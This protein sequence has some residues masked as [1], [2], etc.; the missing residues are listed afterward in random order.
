M[1]ADGSTSIIWLDAKK[2]RRELQPT[3]ILHKAYA[4]LQEL[5]EELDEATRLAGGILEKKISETCV[6]LGGR[7]LVYTL[8]S[9]LILTPR[10]KFRYAEDAINL[11]LSAVDVD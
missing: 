3:R 1:T 5:E 8:N 9:K 7:R 4:R 2:T 6:K 10:A 11:L